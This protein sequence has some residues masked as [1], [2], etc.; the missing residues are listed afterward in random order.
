MELR[1]GIEPSVWR[2]TIRE[3]RLLAGLST[4]ELSRLRDLAVRFLARKTL[5]PVSA[6]IDL[7]PHSRA[8]LALQACLPILELGLDWYSGF[9]AVII[10]PGEFAPEREHADDSG[11]VHVVREELRGEAWEQGPV[12]L[13]WDDLREPAQGDD[14]VSLVIHEFAHKLDMQNGIAN[15]MPPLHRDMRPE[16]WTQA[17]ARAYAG[18]QRQLE[19]SDPT[20][21]DPYAATD[22]AEFFAVAS[23]YFFAAPWIPATA[24]PAV[25]AQLKAF[26]RQDP[27]TR[28]SS[29]ARLPD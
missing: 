18:L 7:S 29:R 28:V 16:A 5:E 20:P 22:P 17:F 11:I 10:Y 25:Y 2:E 4:A 21:I 15:G 1:V 27:L 6:D 13:S 14:G 24:Y 26:Y 23:E 19:R 12:I 8:A 9:H 3:M